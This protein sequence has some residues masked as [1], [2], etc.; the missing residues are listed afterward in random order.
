MRAIHFLEKAPAVPTVKTSPEDK[1]KFIK[2]KL[3]KGEVTDPETIDFIFKILNKPEIQANVQGLLGGIQ[4]KDSDVAQ[5]Q[6][7]NNG[8]LS[9]IIRKL[10]IQKEELDAFLHQWNEGTGFVNTKLLTPGNRGT[11]QDL[12][13]DPIAFKVF[14]VFEDVRS[15]YKLPKKGVSGYG[16]FGLSMLSTQVALKAPGDIEVNGQPIEVKGNDARLYADE[17]TAVKEAFGQFGQPKMMGKDPKKQPQQDV[18]PA[19]GS[20][21]GLL[22]NVVREIA[23]GSSEVIQQAT[24]AFTARG[25][26]NTNRLINSIQK[27]A[28]KNPEQALE[29]LQKEWWRAGFM[30]YQKAINMPIMVIGF[31]Q[32]LISSNPDDFIEWGC[33]PRTVANYGYMFGRQVGQTRETYPKIFVPGHNK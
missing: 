29:I 13:P 19:R 27:T 1:L 26:K 18:T 2:S 4:A 17:K 20:A 15:T 16:E 9:K 33:L 21:P 8:V 3:S 5:F 28:S 30:S 12:I 24:E 6:K 31:G 22:N 23:R 10:P 32:F 11:L 7:L 14:E 25:Y